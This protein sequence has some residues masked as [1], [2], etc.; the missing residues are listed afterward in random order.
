MYC[1]LGA[2]YNSDLDG[3]QS[4]AKIIDSKMCRFSRATLKLKYPEVLLTFIVEYRDES[5]FH[6]LRIAL[7][8]ML[9]MAVSTA[10]C[11]RS[12]SELKLIFSRL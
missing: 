12:F 3:K 2:V 5:V 10:R 9:T 6:S 8:T 1:V 7:Q 11:E 4:Y